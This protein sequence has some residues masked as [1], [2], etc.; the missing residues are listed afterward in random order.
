M[1]K[2][3]PSA[4]SGR[5]CAAIK[6][7][8]PQRKLEPARKHLSDLIDFLRSVA[9]RGLRVQSHA[10]KI[11]VDNSAASSWRGRRR[12]FFSKHRPIRAN[13]RDI[14]LAARA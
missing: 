6:M 5:I 3:V 2:N 11:C 1:S 13:H 12:P 10:A 7:T 14:K 4:R 9:G 8:V